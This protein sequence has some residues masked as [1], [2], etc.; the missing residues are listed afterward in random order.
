MWQEARKQEKLIRGM[1]V[2][3]KR[4]AERRKG[5]YDKI[6]KDP[7]QFL[8]VWGCKAKI[9]I[10]PNVAS[11]ADNPSIM[12]KWRGDEEV[13]IDRF[14]VRS[15][16]D[17]LPEHDDQ[18]EKKN[19]K[20]SEKNEERM[21]NFERYRTLVQNEAL[22]ISESQCLKQIEVDEKYGDK[23]EKKIKDNKAK[24]GYTYSDSSYTEPKLKTSR[25]SHAKLSSDEDSDNDLDLVLDV[26][27]LTS[28]DKVIL[29]KKSTD[30]GMEFGDYIRMM[31]VDNE[32]KEA[33][34]RN[35]ELEIEKSQYS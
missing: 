30:F 1:M 25:F 28:E 17:F 21:L 13:L 33:L 34:K 22:G 19:L 31:I 15:H 12:T 9:H 23:S 11:A 2:D 16:L 18:K 14:D 29:N 35:K 20:E 6:K 10:D 7:A 4:R 27:R 3:Y 8:Q 32:E 24:I 5:F 26:N